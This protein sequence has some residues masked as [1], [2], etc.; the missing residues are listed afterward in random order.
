VAAADSY[1]STHDPRLHFGLGGIERA[2]TVDVRWPDGRH[3]VLHDV[4]SRQFLK[5]GAPKVGAP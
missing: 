5:V 4:T 2:E 1:A 3:T